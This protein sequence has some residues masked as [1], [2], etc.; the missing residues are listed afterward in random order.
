MAD[1]SLPKLKQGWFWEE[2]EVGICLKSS[3]LSRHN[4][5]HGFYT[6]LTNISTH[7]DIREK[8][9]KKLSLHL[10]NQIHSNLILEASDNIYPKRIKG[11]GLISQKSNQSLWLYTADCIPILLADK[12]KGIVAT[13]HAGWKGIATSIISKAIRSIEDLGGSK[14][15]ILVSLGP[16][17]SGSNYEVSFH[18]AERIYRAL[19]IEEDRSH[20]EII[21]FLKELKIL[22]YNEAKEKISLD[23]RFAAFNQLRN[24]EIIPSQIAISEICTYEES[25]LFS[26]WRRDHLIKHQWSFINNN[27]KTNN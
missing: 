7:E 15:S 25:R 12:K 5:V 2:D 1:N 6:K 27:L 4:I 11:D 13:C 20:K 10:T 23:I 26:S 14:S 24:C 18:V 17:I 9:D 3:L 22:T 8:I 16:A 21:D 19:G